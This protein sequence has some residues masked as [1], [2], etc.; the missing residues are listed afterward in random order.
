M[1]SHDEHVW[2]EES[3]LALKFSLSIIHIY[4]IKC[5]P[6][7]TNS[8]KYPCTTIKNRTNS[9][10]TNTPHCKL[11]IKICDG[12][13]TAVE[14]ILQCCTNTIIMKHSSRDISPLKLSILDLSLLRWY[15]TGIDFLWS[16]SMF[17][18][19]Y[20]RIRMTLVTV[21]LSVCSFFLMRGDKIETTDGLRV[22]NE[23]RV[24][25]Y[26]E[27]DLVYGRWFDICWAGCDLACQG[28]NLCTQKWR[29]SLT[30][31]VSLQLERIDIDSEYEKCCT[32]SRL[33]WVRVA[34][35]NQTKRS[36]FDVA[37]VQKGMYRNCRYLS[38]SPIVTTSCIGEPEESVGMKS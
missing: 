35:W 4:C 14:K 8:G 12:S 18:Y 6:V 36:P 25:L 31:Y 15:C 32:T 1:L 28:L 21:C 7:S 27:L 16:S 29:W 9:R 30:S 11:R 23:R 33:V 17:R 20:W 26:A 38:V 37:Q 19:I 34:F 3:A 2:R 24:F 13:R 22:F 10:R 5:K